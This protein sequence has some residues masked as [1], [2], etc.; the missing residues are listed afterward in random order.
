MRSSDF[1]E[2]TGVI[3]S[4]TCFYNEMHFVISCEDGDYRMLEIEGAPGR[5]KEL[6]NESDEERHIRYDLGMDTNIVFTVRKTSQGIVF[7]RWKVMRQL[8]EVVRYMV[9]KARLAEYK[10]RMQN[11]MVWISELRPLVNFNITDEII[12]DI[13][14]LLKE[15]P[16]VVSVDR[17]GQLFTI[18]ASFY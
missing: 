13:H 7:W 2:F 9:D 8:S 11:A 5:G 4:F 18:T 10:D 3:S 6:S 12:D 16:N 1:S 14:A 17:N 15:H